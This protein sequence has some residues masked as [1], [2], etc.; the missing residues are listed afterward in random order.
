M[1]MFTFFINNESHEVSNNSYTFTAT[2]NEQIFYFSSTNDDTS[3]NNKLPIW[4]LGLNLSYSGTDVIVAK[5]LIP[6]KTY[7]LKLSVSTQSSNTDGK[8]K[9][10]DI[11]GEQFNVISIEKKSLTELLAMKEDLENGTKFYITGE[12][13][14]GIEEM[15]QNVYLFRYS[16]DMKGWGTTEVGFLLIAMSRDNGDDT[17]WEKENKI[18]VWDKGNNIEWKGENIQLQNLTDGKE[19]C[20]VM[21]NSTNDSTGKGKHL[22][23]FEA[24][25]N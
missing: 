19:Y 2:A 5:N 17:W 23:I 16:K 25:D 22:E 15:D 11:E 6:G 9:H 1:N 10:V 12:I 20:L 24:I 7:T 8:A 4:D 18:S 14:A 13:C 21:T 3:E